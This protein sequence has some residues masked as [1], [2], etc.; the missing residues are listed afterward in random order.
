MEVSD[1]T[2]VPAALPLGVG[3]TVLMKIVR[4]RRGGP[5]SR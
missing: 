5:R 2:R 1:R 4:G 3:T